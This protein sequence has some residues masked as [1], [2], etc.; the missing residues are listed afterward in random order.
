MTDHIYP[1]TLLWSG[2]TGEGLRAYTRDHRATAPPATAP[3][4]LSPDPPMLIPGIVGRVFG[5]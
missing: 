1:T 3:V 5:G 4:E 2:S